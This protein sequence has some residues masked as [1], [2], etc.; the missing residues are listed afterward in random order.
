MDL[1]HPSTP[2]IA[3]ALTFQNFL[4]S[5]EPRKSADV[6]FPKEQQLQH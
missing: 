3:I 4:V 5:A 2:E 6:L 1:P